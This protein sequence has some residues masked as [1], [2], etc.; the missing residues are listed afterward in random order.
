MIAHTVEVSEGHSV[1][2]SF[3]R[4]T[5]AN[6]NKWSW[7][8]DDAYNHY[9]VEYMTSFNGFDFNLAAENTSMDMDSADSRIVLGVS[10]T[11]SF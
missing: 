2:V 5:S 1:K 3:D 11:F 10:R 7:D 4:S 9:R 6:E 8:G